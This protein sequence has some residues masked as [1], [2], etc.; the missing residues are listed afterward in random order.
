MELLD[1]YLEAVKKHLPWKRQDDIIAELRANLEA[2]LE[3]K[4][5]ALGR[6]L[7]QGESEDWLRQIG[8]PRQ[9]AARYQPQR[10]LIGPAIF[11]AYIHVLRTALLWAGMIYIVANVIQIAATGGEAAQASWVLLGVPG[12][13]FTV[14]AWVTLVFIVLEAVGRQFP[15]KMPKEL[16]ELLGDSTKWSPAELPALEKAQAKGKRPRTYAMAVTEVVFGFLA[17]GWLLL[18]PQNPYLLMGPGA[19]YLEASPFKLAPVWMTFFWSIVAL[20]LLQAVWRWIDLIRDRW[21]HPGVV[22]KVVFKL[23]GLVPLVILL[24]AQPQACVLLKHPELDHERLGAALE[25]INTAIH[26]GFQ[27]IL[28]IVV[29]ELAWEAGNYFWKVYRMQPGE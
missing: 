13:L 12:L 20:N 5:E 28:A 8:L 4:Q 18:I 9:V 26:R 29:L 11:G 14:A 2:Q 25:Q 16:Q 15:E 27:I 22:R 19:A 24:A 1:R 23:G 10:Y 6:P 3:D 17:T 7:T 21:Q